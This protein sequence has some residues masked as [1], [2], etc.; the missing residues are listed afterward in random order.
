MVGGLLE[1][2]KIN[3]ALLDSYPS[4]EALRLVKTFRN[5]VCRII[6]LT[7][8]SGSAQVFDGKYVATREKTINALKDSDIATLLL[9]VLGQPDFNVVAKKLGIAQENKRYQHVVS[10]QREKSK[11]SRP[12]M[13]GGKSIY[14]S[15]LDAACERYG[16]TLEYVLWGVPLLNLQLML[17]DS[18]K[19]AYLD[20]Q[21]ERDAE[22][23]NGD[24]RATMMEQINRMNW[25]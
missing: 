24:D 23:I 12:V 18:V 22:H 11:G 25:N 7:T 21:G 19:T 20:E 9:V 1:A 15:I 5:Q 17:A 10:R 4:I 6:A 13:F 14:G 8:L 2:I 3:R 16:W